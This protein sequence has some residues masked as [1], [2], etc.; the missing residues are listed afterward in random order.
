MMK[1]QPSDL[2]L[3]C[4]SANF[5]LRNHLAG[6]DDLQIAASGLAPFGRNKPA[7]LE[8]FV[9]QARDYLGEKPPA[10]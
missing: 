1:D 4:C 6:V 10:V 3:H 5:K 8:I 7:P 2:F 9:T